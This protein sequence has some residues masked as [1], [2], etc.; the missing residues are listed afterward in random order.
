MIKQG[1]VGIAAAYLHCKVV[2]IR[3]EATLLLGLLLSSSTGLSKMSI[4]ETFT[5]LKKLLFDEE[6]EVRNAISWTICRIVLSRA[7]T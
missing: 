4:N 1:A 3:R 7:G 5:G 2:S 6:L